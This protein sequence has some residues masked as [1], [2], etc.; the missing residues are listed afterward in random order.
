[1]TESALQSWL[2][3][4]LRKAGGWWIPTTGSVHM[5]RGTPD[6]VGCFTGSMYAL[7]L[8][9]EKGKVRNL[10]LWTLEEIEK[11]GGSSHLI[12]GRR[13]AEVFLESLKKGET[14]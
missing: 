14:A 7:E 13:E 2:L 6:V 4:E 11:H 5:P 1:M 10:Q 8:K 12:R 9:T 3:K